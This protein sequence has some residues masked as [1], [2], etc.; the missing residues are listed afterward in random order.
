MNFIREGNLFANIDKFLSIREL[1]LSDCSESNNETIERFNL[2]R[3]IL[4]FYL[5][6]SLKAHR[7]VYRSS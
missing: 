1:E 3:V 6:E 4:N 7:D 5:R 2:A